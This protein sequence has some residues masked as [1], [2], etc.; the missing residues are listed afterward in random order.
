MDVTELVTTIREHGDPSRRLDLWVP[1][2]LTLNGGDVPH[3]I[4]MAIVG[5]AVLAIGL[6]MD[7]FTPGTDGRTYHYKPLD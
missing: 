7:G 2:Q 4:A 5:D 1:D 6:T 3:D